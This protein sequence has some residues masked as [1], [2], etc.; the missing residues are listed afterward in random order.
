MQQGSTVKKLKAQR[1]SS[2]RGSG[3]AWA[4]KSR[5]TCKNNTGEDTQPLHPLSLLFSSPTGFQSC[6]QKEAHPSGREQHT[7]DVSGR[8][9]GKRFLKYLV[10]GTHPRYGAD[11]VGDG[12]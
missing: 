1:C 7:G 8:E 2:C 6:S 3:G 12:D 4:K 10:K 9:K 11:V 5:G